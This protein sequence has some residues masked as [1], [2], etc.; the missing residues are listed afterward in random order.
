MMLR[1][2]IRLAEIRT[3]NSMKWLKRFLLVRRL[4]KA[5]RMMRDSFEKTHPGQVRVKLGVGSASIQFTHENLDLTDSKATAQMFRDAADMLEAPSQP[6]EFGDS[7]RKGG[8]GAHRDA[9]YKVLH[10]KGNSKAAK[11]KRGSALTQR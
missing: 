10:G 7:K 4:K 11:T 6:M 1:H 2:G 9:A 8:I 3:E 5:E